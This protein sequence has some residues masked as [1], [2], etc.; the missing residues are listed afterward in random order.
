MQLT[1]ELVE[2][3]DIPEI[4]DPEPEQ[5]NSEE[6]KESESDKVEEEQHNIVK[7]KVANVGGK[8]KNS[9]QEI[10]A[11]KNVE[12]DANNYSNCGK[13]FEEK[14]D[15]DRPHMLHTFSEKLFCSLCTETFSNKK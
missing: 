5:Q 3:D 9:N 2:E 10:T 15:T 6:P 4:N 14:K 8:D 7:Q 11:D 12:E 1:W 13:T